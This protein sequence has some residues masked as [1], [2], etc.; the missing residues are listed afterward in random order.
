M[1]KTRFHDAARLIVAL[2]MGF[3]LLAA[4]SIAGS[5]QE[6]PMLL[7]V[8][9]APLV[10]ET[11]RGE[12]R[13]SIEVADNDTERSRGLMFRRA[14]PDDRGMLF[15]F[16][17]TR[18]VGF[19]MKNTPMPLDLVFIGE[20]GVVKAIMKGIPFSEASIAPAEPVRFVLELKAGTAQ[21]AGIAEGD[22]MRHPRIDEIAGAN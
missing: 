2:V 4:G 12:Q 5:A 15:I 9:A 14:M 10:V 11:A 17:T 13:F 3:V 7:P 6:Q 18:R 22:R 20:D 19:W 8:D 1:P 16:E 21:K